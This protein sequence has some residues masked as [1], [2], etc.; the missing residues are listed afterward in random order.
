MKV[1]SVALL[2]MTCVG[3]S[4]LFEG[5]NGASD[6]IGIL[7]PDGSYIPGNVSVIKINSKTMK[8]AKLNCNFNIL[9]SLNY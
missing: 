8:L 3:T 6:I 7:S 5:V 9:R 4:L 1:F 2:C